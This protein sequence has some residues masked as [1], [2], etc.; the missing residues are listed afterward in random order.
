MGWLRRCGLDLSPMNSTDCSGIYWK[1]TCM[2]DTSASSTLKVLNDNVLYT[3]HLYTLS[4]SL[5]LQSVSAQDQNRKK[6]NMEHRTNFNIQPFILFLEWFCQI[7]FRKIYQT[8]L[9]SI[10]RDGRTI[11]ADERF[12]VSFLIPQGTLPWQP[13]LWANRCRIYIL[14]LLTEMLPGI[15][16]GLLMG[17]LT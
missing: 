7:D 13:I 17:F 4:F 10:C 9:H 12:E 6:Q 8:D 1:C 14:A 16:I 11:A 2:C 5:T 15:L 3:V